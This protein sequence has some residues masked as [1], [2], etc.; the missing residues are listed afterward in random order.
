MIEITKTRHDLTDAQWESIK[1]FMPKVYGRPGSPQRQFINAL[2][3]INKTGSQWRDLP[4]R[5][6]KWNT[7]FKRFADWSD[8]GHILYIFKKLQKMQG[9]DLE[10]IMLDSTSVKAHKAAAG[11]LKKMANKALQETVQA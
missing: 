8:K 9:M 1:H 11:A 2:L 7:V 10:E 5:Y 6:G 4:E 3:Y